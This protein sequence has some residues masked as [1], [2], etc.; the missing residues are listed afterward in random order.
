MAKSATKR[1]LLFA[2]LAGKKGHI[3]TLCALVTKKLLITGKTM[4]P[5][6]IADITIL[7]ISKKNL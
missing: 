7:Q 1:G 2:S 4:N 3:N 6:I 5:P